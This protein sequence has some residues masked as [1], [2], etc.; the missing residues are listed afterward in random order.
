[1]ERPLV[2]IIVP[3]YNQEKYVER[4]LKSIIAQTYKNIEIIV[5][6]DG[7]TDKSLAICKEIANNDNRVHIITQKNA[8]LS[9]ARNTGLKNMNGEII[10]F[11]DSDDWVAENFIEDNV[12]LLIKENADIVCFNLKE[13]YNDRI[14]DICQFR[15]DMSTEAIAEGLILD[16][17]SNYVWNKIYRKSIWKDKSFPVG[18]NFEDFYIMA[19]LVLASKK[20]IANSKSYYFYEK[21]NE[22][23]Y[24]NR[25]NLNFKYFF[26]AGFKER[27][28]LLNNTENKLYL[29][30]IKLMLKNALRAYNDNLYV[31]N[32]STQQLNEI[33][34]CFVKYYNFKNLLD[35]K[36]RLFLWGY[37][38][39]KL[40]N[41]YKGLE[42]YFNA[43]R[44]GW[45]AKK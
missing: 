15:N 38:H 37:F 1:M 7:S 45:F 36:Y 9:A 29:E 39:C 25:Y 41:R 13:V 18:M 35:F 42:F 24:T 44:N 6:N 21:R 20:I 8:G 33:H 26:F 31:G 12:L 43:K 28:R 10:A 4:C 5:V 17:I 19:S 23:S 27:V 2:S 3:V 16:K 32:L 11:V 34:E 40:I 30:C 22:N 14:V